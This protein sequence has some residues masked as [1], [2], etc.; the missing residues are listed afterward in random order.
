MKALPGTGADVGAAVCSISCHRLVVAM[1]NIGVSTI[2][3][4][5]LLNA[6]TGLKWSQV[7]RDKN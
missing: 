3:D 6:A 4:F 2:K 7:S 1:W 5:C